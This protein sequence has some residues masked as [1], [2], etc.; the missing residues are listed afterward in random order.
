MTE[1]V[2]FTTPA[3]DR[4]FVLPL[5]CS[6]AEGDLRLVSLTGEERHV[7]AAA[8]APHEVAREQAQVH[9]RNHV[10]QALT[11][12]V[13][14]LT[15]VLRV[16]DDRPPNLERL[17]ERL[18]LTTNDRHAVEAALRDLAADV[19]TITTIVVSDRPA[20][21]EAAYA[22]L[23]ACGR[24][25]GRALGELSRRLVEVRRVDRRDGADPM[26]DVLRT[27]T[28][29][30]S[31]G[32]ETPLHRRVDELLARLE[33]TLGPYVGHDPGGD[34]AQRQEEYRRDARSAIADSLRD[35][36]FTPF[37]GFH[38]Q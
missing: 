7:D 11:G 5:E 23:E 29:P 16:S 21:L 4:F 25:A 19:Q 10:E 3:V 15:R 28:D 1:G 31:D 12:V 18:G 32:S 33:R 20:D 8:V 37:T 35:S 38:G 34:R 14:M 27:L 13:D 2:L 36:G 6:P 30:A 9:V 26:A 22:R 17:A 24:D